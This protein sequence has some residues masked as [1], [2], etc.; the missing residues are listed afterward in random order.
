MLKVSFYQY[1]LEWAIFHHILVV[2]YSSLF[3]CIIQMKKKTASNGKWIFSYQVSYKNW[4]RDIPNSY[5]SNNNNSWINNN[6]GNI[7]SY[8]FV[9]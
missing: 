7:Y 3:V 8:F 5:D 4:V 1:A 2:A 6:Y 9:W